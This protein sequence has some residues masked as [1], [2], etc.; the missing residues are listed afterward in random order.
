[1]PPTHTHTERCMHRAGWC[2]L[3]LALA[4]V[5]NTASVVQ[6]RELM[7]CAC[8]RAPIRKFGDRL[9]A[10][11]TLNTVP[12][13]GFSS[14]RAR[15]TRLFMGE[16]RERSAPRTDQGTGARWSL[17]PSDHPLQTKVL[18]VAAM[19]PHTTPASP[20]AGHSAESGGGGTSDDVGHCILGAGE[21]MWHDT[22]AGAREG[23]AAKPTTR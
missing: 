1:M 10:G 6:Q 14:K 17:S 11:D 4:Q 19:Q 5:R 2:V 20:H 8:T 3:I 23:V 22:R 21:R 9:G 12:S 13:S 18:I 15:G 16:V 7:S